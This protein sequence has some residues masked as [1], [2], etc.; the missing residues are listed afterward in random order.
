MFHKVVVPMGLNLTRFDPVDDF[1][2]K[3]DLY[4]KPMTMFPFTDCKGRSASTK[5]I[6]NKITGHR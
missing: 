2:R 4:S 3:I 1:I 5:W 6:K